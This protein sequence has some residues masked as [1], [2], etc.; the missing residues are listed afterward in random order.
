VAIP[1][2]HRYCIECIHDFWDQKDNLGVFSCPQCAQTFSPRPFLNDATLADMVDKPK[3]LELPGNSEIC[4]NY[5][6][7]GVTCDFCTSIKQKAVKSCLVCLASYC[8][9]HLQAHNKSPALKK[10]KLI[11]ASVN[12]N[13]QEKICPHHHHQYLKIYCR[14][15]QQ[16]M[17][18][19]C[20]GGPQRS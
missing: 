3:K 17:S 20:D 14:T 19:V 4:S 5:M 10:H 7:G 9:N 15:D 1:C 16:C 12:L 6:Q 2:G 11:E 13:L 8:Q 18:F